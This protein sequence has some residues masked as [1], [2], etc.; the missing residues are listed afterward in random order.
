MKCSQAVF[1]QFPRTSHSCTNQVGGF[2]LS[3][4]YESTTIISKDGKSHVSTTNKLLRCVKYV[5]DLCP[6]CLV[7]E[8]P[9][10]PFTSPIKIMFTGEMEITITLR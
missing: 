10:L 7:V 6:H 1:P 5:Y 3:Q 4:R 8:L 9:C 2:N